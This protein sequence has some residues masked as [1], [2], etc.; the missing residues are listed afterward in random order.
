MSQT[1][2][3]VER[4]PTARGGESIVARVAWLAAAVCVLLVAACAKESPEVLIQSAERHLAERDFRTAQIE[5]RNAIR[6]AP[7]SGSGHRLLGIALLGGGDPV[8]AEVVLRKALSLTQ[9]PDDVLPSLALSLVRQGEIERVTTE[10]GTRKLQEPAADAPF[11]TSLGQAWLMRGDVNRAGDAFTAALAD[12][13][14][15]PP[16]RLGQ[17]RILAQGGNID[18]ASSITD[19]VLAADP[20]LLEGHTF[21]AQLLLS[22][23]RRKEAIVPLEKALAIDSS[24]VPAR[25]ALVSLRI[26]ERDYDKSQSVLDAA[27][28]PFASDPRLAYL[29]GLLALRKGDLKKARDETSAILRQAPDHVGSLVLAGEIELRS[30]NLNLAEAHLQKALYVNSGAA[31]ARR[32]LAVTYLREGR[33]VKALDVL[34]PLLQQSDPKDAQLMLLAGEAYL[35]SGDL[36]RASEFFE[37]SKAG[38]GSEAPARLRLGQIAMT[39]GDFDRSV[40]ELQAASALDTQHQQAD[41]LLFALQM[42]RHDPRKALAAAEGF[43]KKQPDNPLGRVLAGTAHLAGKDLASARQEFDTALKIKP[44]YFPALRGLADVDE[45]EGHAGEAIR[46]YQD[47]IASKP[48]DEQLLVALA[49]LQE[50]MG[51]AAD[52]GATLRRAIAANPKSASPYVALV[53]SHLRRR[54]P[55]LAVAVAEEAVTANPAQPRLVELLGNTQDAVG[56]GDGGVKAFQELVGLEPQSLAPQTRLAAVQAKQRDFNGAARTLR[57]AQRT[58]PDNERIARD[59]VAVYMA[60]AK[61]DDALAVAKTLQERKAGSALGNTLEG[62]V[63]AAR[64]KWPEAERAYRVALE[65]QPQS[66]A[67]AIGL[68]RVL[69][70]SGRKGESAAFLKSWI[71]RYPADVSMRMYIADTALRAKDYKAAALQYEAALDQ[72]PDNVPALNNLAWTLGEL[73]DPRALGFAERAVALAPDSPIALDTLGMLH[74]EQGDPKKAIESLTRVRELAPDRK[75]LRLHYAMG[76]LSA[77][78]SEEGKAELRQ[79][80]SSPEDFPGKASIPAL[81]GKL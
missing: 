23:G 18:G 80:S 66:S 55:K 17:A 71:S 70:V 20:R 22:Q 41:L 64:Q 79:L 61:F 35:A 42:R 27:T 19:E 52:S 58:A 65:R 9:R 60:A 62:E 16:A 50:R 73:K 59:L 12:V 31:P 10:F 51:D 46:R 29:R 1:S 6:L 32:L 36:A 76:L 30:D 38:A 68:S 43:M 81:L 37:S 56:A 53:K 5:L 77:G 34:Q 48:D 40:G 63:Q 75:D 25:V 54:E 78:R 14:G 3:G 67:I 49:E 74:L 7:E 15:Y 39:R 2:V 33:A 57:Q 44:D 4:R 28:A 21:K 26:D 8:A 24:D 47:R 11:Q 45:A 69:S 13:P 72:A